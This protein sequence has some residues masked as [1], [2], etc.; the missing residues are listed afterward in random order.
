[1]LIFSAIAI[2]LP[3][4]YWTMTQW[5]KGFAYK[6]DIGM[7]PLVISSAICIVIA[8]GAAGYQAVKAAFIDPAKT[9]RSE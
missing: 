6:T 4:A 2:G 3:L 7:G 8:L 1:M 5:L 9:L